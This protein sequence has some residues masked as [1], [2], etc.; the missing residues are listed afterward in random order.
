M[1]R[2]VARRIRDRF[3]PGRVVV[4]VLV[5]AALSLPGLEV[6]STDVVRTV[7]AVAVI[8]PLFGYLVERSGVDIDLGLLVIA[9]GVVVGWG[10]YG[11]LQDGVG[12][13]GWLLLALGGWLCL[14][15]LD[16]FVRDDRTDDAGGG[17][18]DDVRATSDETDD[19]PRAELAK[20]N[21]CN[22]RLAETPRDADRPLSADEIR[23]RANLTPAE[24]DRLREI[25]GESG[26]IDRL[27]TGYRLDEREM[28]LTGILRTIGRR[29]LRPVRVL[30]PGRRA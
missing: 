20:L 15:G 13:L 7:V 14:E 28:G 21:E 8:A 2:S 1:S 16:R 26:P 9:L 24:F 5:V 11:H 19:L 3:D 25:H 18:I 4:A 10:G 29:L 17:R 22:C 27:G 30:R 23:S 6:S 12:W